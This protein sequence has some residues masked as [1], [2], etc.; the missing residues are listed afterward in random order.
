VILSTRL[1]LIVAAASLGV[2]AGLM[3]TA[4]KDSVILLAILTCMLG[5]SLY[6]AMSRD[7]S[8][9]QNSV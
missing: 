2:E 7:E 3:T 5:P 9:A 8:K 4:M 1:S 6:K